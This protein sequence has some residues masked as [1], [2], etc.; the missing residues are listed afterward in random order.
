VRIAYIAAGAA[1]M[2]CGNCLRDHALAVAVNRLG[3]E[4]VL[5]PTYTPLRTDLPQGEETLGRR[6]FFNGIRAY[7]A[8]KLAYF[9]KPRP[10]L[11][12]VL[13][14]RLVVGL[15][16]RLSGSTDPARLGDMT[17][18][19]LRGEDG[20]QRRELDELVAWLRDELRPDVVQ[21]TNALLLGMARRL[22][23]ELRVPVLCSLQSEDIFFEGLTE[24]Y[25]DA[26]AELVRERGGEVDGL[27]AV[28]EFHAD[29]AAE[30][31]GLPRQTISVV[32]PGVPLDGHTVRE[33]GKYGDA[34][35]IGF[36]SRL[37]PEKGLDIL[38]ESFVSLVQQPGLERAR[39]R[40]AGY[41]PNR[42]ISY[43]AAWRR[44][45]AMAGL[46]DRV[47]FLG[48]IQRAE[49][50]AFLD[51]IDV[52]AVPTRHPEP[53]GM[54]VLEAL[55]SGVPVVLPEHGAF[56]ELVGR[57]GG[58]VLTR[59]HDSSDLARVLGEVLTDRDR[60]VALGA[61]GRRAAEEFFHAERMARE[62][63]EVYRRVVAA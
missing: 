56:P 55:A 40:V 41:L 61:S 54:F 46:A 57:S 32:Y 37:A 23:E 63:C 5:I 8:Q 43:V 62:T 33:R 16:S 9:R 35:T 17:L 20:H 4:L 29:W 52:L 34:P 14:S 36:L 22:K 2:Y 6:L 53:K 44:H 31:F 45:L 18:S 49:K 12:R 7:A 39:L 50:L 13:G 59:P 15:L 10:I 19:M 26:C 42:S 30:T 3:D 47:E 11:D 58:G 38:C 60:L 27:L 48:T 51:G 25:R 21:I 24:A 1:G 28:S